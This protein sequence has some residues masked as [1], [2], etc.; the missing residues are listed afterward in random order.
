MQGHLMVEAHHCTGCGSCMLACS[1]AKEGEF[2]LSLSRIQVIGNIVMG[3]PGVRQ[4][5][6][7]GYLHRPGRVQA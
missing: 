2:S 6:C 1:L 7:A 3:N 4:T 5:H